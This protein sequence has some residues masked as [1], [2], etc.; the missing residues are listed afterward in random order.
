M[1]ELLLTPD[2][3]GPLVGLILG[4]GGAEYGRRTKKASAKL[5]AESTQRKTTR[6]EERD[7]AIVPLILWMAEHPDKPAPS[8]MRARAKVLLEIVDESR[9]GSATVPVPEVTSMPGEGD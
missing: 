8:D 5:V 7:L 6:I 3:I 1:L 9:G 4:G 2:V